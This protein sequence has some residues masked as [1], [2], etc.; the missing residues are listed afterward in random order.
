VEAGPLNATLVLLGAIATSVI[1]VLAAKWADKRK[2]RATPFDLLLKQ[3]SQLI[4]VNQQQTYALRILVP[5]L[6]LWIDSG[7]Q[8]PKPDTTELRQA[9]KEGERL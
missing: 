3:N 1:T 6:I 5:P 4:N 2:E 8:G 7:C 9:L